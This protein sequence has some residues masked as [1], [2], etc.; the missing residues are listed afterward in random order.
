MTFTIFRHV[1]YFAI[2]A[3]QSTA[4]YCVLKINFVSKTSWYQKTWLIKP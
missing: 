4:N 2:K 3:K 1:Y